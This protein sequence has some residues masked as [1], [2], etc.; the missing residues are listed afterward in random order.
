LPSRTGLPAVA[1]TGAHLSYYGGRVVSNARV[2]AV[3]WGSGSYLPQL[4]GAGTPNIPSFYA[5]VLQ[6]PYVDWLAEYNTAGRLSIGGTTTNQVIGRGSYLGQYTIIPAAAN[7]GATISDAQIQAELASQLTAGHLP[8]PSRDAS[9]NANT[10][11]AVFFPHGKTITLGAD[12]SCVLSSTGFCAYHGTLPHSLGEVYYGVH[13]DM[14][15]GSGCANIC[16]GSSS[17]FSNQTSVASHELIETITDPEVG[18]ASSFAPP[19]GWYDSANNAEIGDLC[20]AQEST[21]IGGDGLTYVVQQQFSNS[22]NACIVAAPA[23]AK[24]AS[25]APL[26][27]WT[28]A[29]LAL[30]MLG[31]A[32]SR[33][34]QRSRD[35]AGAAFRH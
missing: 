15:A 32:R 17:V 34:A 19:L 9:G 16:G 10:Y 35:D 3:L 24:S 26:P 11:Y 8:P 1:P 21:V 2:V 4:T 25:D 18:I 20:N 31:M 30:A 22:N 5:G 33:F 7:N 28:Y 13:P 6:S 12:T 23:A 29:A 27:L 14:Q